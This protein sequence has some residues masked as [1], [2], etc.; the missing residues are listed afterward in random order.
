MGYRFLRFS[1]VYAGY[2]YQFLSKIPD[3]ESLSYEELYKKFIQTRYSTSDFYERNLKEHGNEVQQFYSSVEFFQK[4]WARDNSVS[5]RTNNW[6]KDIIISQVIQYQPD[7]IFLNDIYK[8]NRD[9][10]NEIREAYDKNVII[11]GSL[12][13]Y[14]ND[15]ASFNDLDLMITGVPSFYEN[16]TKAGCNAYFMPF[17]FEKTL[18]NEITRQKTPDIDFAFMGSLGNGIDNFSLRYAL[19]DDLLKNT[20]ITVWGDIE[21]KRLSG[22]D[23]TALNYSYK[24]NKMMNFFRISTDIRKKIPF[25]R[26]AANCVLDPNYP[27][28]NT[29][30]PDRIHRPIFG[31]EYYS[32]MANSKIVLN[33][34]H[35]E[36]SSKFAANMR[37]FEATG[38]GTCLITDWKE[39]LSTLFEPDT[40]VVTYRDATE[41]IKKVKYLLENPAEREAIAKAGQ[42]RTLKDHTYELRM[43]EINKEINKLL[44]KK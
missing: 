32:A 43:A 42:Q 29:I 12:T 37:L 31:L 35:G 20:P 14:T 3:H 2:I 4:A 5:F 39:N 13:A 19:I 36:N 10:R 1:P 34:H 17:A 7:I 16:F 22:F 27:A 6:Y 33:V 30:Y 21:D 24:I 8:I 9:V 26:L 25:I 23:M 11:I 38:T 18:L 41:C 15:F 28:L 40:E 44:S